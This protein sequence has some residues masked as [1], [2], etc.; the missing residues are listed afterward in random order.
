MMVTIDM[1]LFDIEDITAIVIDELFIIDG[2]GSLED[3]RKL[4]KAYLFCLLH[5]SIDI[6]MF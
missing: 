3:G 2:I 4:L 6:L 1:I 5:T